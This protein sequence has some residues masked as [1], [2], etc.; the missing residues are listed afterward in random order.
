MAQTQSVTFPP[1]F[2]VQQ[3]SGSALC[4]LTSPLVMQ[5][6]HAG[7]AWALPCPSTCSADGLQD[8]QLSGCSC[9]EMFNCSQFSSR[10]CPV[11][12]CSS[13]RCISS[14]ELTWLGSQG[15]S[16]SKG[17]NEVYIKIEKR[18][19]GLNNALVSWILMLACQLKKFSFCPFFFFSFCWI[20]RQNC[21]DIP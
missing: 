4:K 2:R 20:I 1:Q 9:A 12:H 3:G 16:G 8:A 18:N 17:P 5:R 14:G 7:A 11:Q 10:V 13:V 6:G 15:Q 19:E 21:S